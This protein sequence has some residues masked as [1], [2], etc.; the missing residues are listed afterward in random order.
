MNLCVFCAS[1]SQLAPEYADAGRK[2]GT[3]IG[4]GRHTLVWGGCNVGLMDI[5]GQAASAAGAHTVAV[6]PRFLVERG[7]AFRSADEQVVTADMAERKAVMRQRAHAFVALPG[8]VGTW[9]EVLEVLA[10]KKLGQLDGPFQ[11]SRP[12]GQHGQRAH[13]DRP[14]VLANLQGYFDPLLSQIRRSLDEGFSPPDLERLYH[15]AHTAEEILEQ[16][17]AS[18]P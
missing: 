16:L 13:F 11:P 3:W 5:V 4:Q 9:E 2:L 18:F 12:L 10:L 15:V 17:D 7:L 6:I 1:S 14:I 8:G